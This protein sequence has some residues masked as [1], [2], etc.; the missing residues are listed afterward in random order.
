[1]I[2]L[3]LDT[4]LFVFFFGSTVFDRVDGLILSRRRR[5][6]CN[7]ANRKIRKMPVCKCKAFFTIGIG[8]Q[9]TEG[10][11]VEKQQQP[12]QQHRS[13]WICSMIKPIDS[14]LTGD[15]GK[16]AGKR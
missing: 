9:K 2:Q 14:H 8:Y 11:A 13:E 4:R 6:H 3:L 7:L 15:S 5:M 12:Q 16:P 10:H 1:M